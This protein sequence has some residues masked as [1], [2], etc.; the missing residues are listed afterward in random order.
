MEYFLERIA[1]LLY[2]ESGGNLNSHCLVF[3]NRRAGL[4][5]L[6]YLSKQISKPLCAPGILTINDLFR[7]LSK[8]QLAENELLLLELYKVYRKVKKT[9]ESFEDFFYWGDM[10]LN[11]FD[12]LDKYLADPEKLF[13]HVA[14]IRKIDQQFGG[15]TDEQAEIVK[16]FWTNFDTTKLTSE[17]AGF[18]SIWS[19]LNDLYETF[20]NSLREMN[21]AYEGMIFRDVAES[22]SWK[23]QSM[24]K[25]EMMHFIGFNALNKCEKSIMLGLKESGKARFYWDYD[26]S[27]IGETNLNSAGYFLRTNIRIFGNDMPDDWNC[28]TLLSGDQKGV[29]QRVIDTSSDIAQVKLIPDLIR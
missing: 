23:D 3:P 13:R 22:E 11:D 28:T 17:K 7:S 9:E 4:F 1:K 14:D 16:R 6:K 12:D 5:F 8:L 18:I 21:I 15:L 2:A 27:Y 26:D 10:L 29:K 20:R 25:W 24:I 19:V